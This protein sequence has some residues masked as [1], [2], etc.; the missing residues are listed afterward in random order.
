M[1]DN[2]LIDLEWESFR[3]E[4]KSLDLQKSLELAIRTTDTAVRR[5]EK[6]LRQ[7]RILA[8]HLLDTQDRLRLS[9][10]VI[11]HLESQEISLGNLPAAL[12]R[13]EEENQHLRE[14][15]SELQSIATTYRSDLDSIR[16]ECLRLDNENDRLRSQRRR[17]AGELLRALRGKR[18]SESINREL[19]WLVSTPGVAFFRGVK[20]IFRPIVKPVFKGFQRILIA[21]FTGWRGSKTALSQ[22]ELVDG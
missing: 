4:K 2:V 11:R 17:I 7:R 10:R 8:R 9:V 16:L 15:F 21:P 6:V 22:L 5:L 20:V 1:N 12:R 13:Q 19:L 14:Q 18:R 3:T